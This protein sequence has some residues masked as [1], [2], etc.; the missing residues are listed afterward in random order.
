MI[1]LY[2]C[3]NINYF[4]NLF[5]VR[6]DSTYL[7][8]MIALPLSPIK[9]TKFILCLSG[10]LSLNPQVVLWVKKKQNPVYLN[11]NTCMLC[12][13]CTFDSHSLMNVYTNKQESVSQYKQFLNPG[14][15]KFRRFHKYMKT[16]TRK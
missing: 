15:K 4:Y 10:N 6:R 16:S 8:L 3:N 12:V 11:R 7:Y 9:H 1:M 5:Y 13:L 14:R 2:Y